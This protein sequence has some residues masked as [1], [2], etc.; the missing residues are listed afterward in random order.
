MTQTTNNENE[1]GYAWARRP[2]SSS[3]YPGSAPAAGSGFAAPGGRDEDAPADQT[4][5]GPQRQTGQPY[6]EQPQTEQPQT[7]QPYPNGQYQTGGQ[8]QQRE[9]YQQYPYVSPDGQAQAGA[10]PIEATQTVPQYPASAPAAPG[11]W[12]PEGSF[13]PSNTG[14]TGGGMPP[15]GPPPTS[16]RQ[17]RRPGWGGVLA[18]GVGSA[19]LASLLTAGIV[20]QTQDS[21]SNTTSSFGTTSE[22]QVK[23]P[24]TASNASSPDW[25]AVAKA[26]EPS[27]VAVKV[28]GQSGSGEGSGVILDKTG[29]IVTNNHVV[30]GVGSDATVQVVLADGRGYAATVVGT[31]PSTDLAVIKLT[32]PPTDLTPAVFGSSSTVKVG[33]PVMAVGNPLGLAGT[34]TTGI[35]SATDRPTTT[36]GESTDPTAAQGE[37]VITNAIQTDAAVNPGNSG[38]ALV[39]AQGRVI[40]V[41]SSIASLGTSS[42]SGESS[43]SGNIGLGFAIPVDEVK[44]VSSQLIKGGTVSHAWLGVGPADVSVTVD[45]ASRDAAQLKEIL[46][47]G[48]AEKA[49]LKVGDAVIA[50]DGEPVNSASSLVGQLRERQAGADVK[51]TVVRDGKS[52]DITVTLGTKPASAN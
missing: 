37:T 36:P 28:S 25:G 18:V 32:K 42:V 30:S 15:A 5:T 38:G 8:Y 27:V 35:V 43:Q 11:Q 12:Y 26:V 14:S 21:S 46:S 20:L 47:G 13:G 29:R 41:P 33:D 4:L 23:A 10:T 2:G 3:E 24:V 7:G 40:G 39:D 45:G 48:P 44:D 22:A 16:R 1:H 17:P 51:L 31:D 50:V 34:V 19:A 6:T 52:T 9:G 49:G